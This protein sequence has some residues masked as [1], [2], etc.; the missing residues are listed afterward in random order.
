ML[1]RLTAHLR[2]LEK[3]LTAIRTDLAAIEGEDSYLL[4]EIDECLA[5]L[6]NTIGSLQGS[7]NAECIK[8][9]LSWL[10]VVAGTVNALLKLFS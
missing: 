4:T 3:E 8:E 9:V 1:N 7:A 2:N 10:N 5:A 6:K